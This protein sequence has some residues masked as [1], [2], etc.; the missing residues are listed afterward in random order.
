MFLVLS[1]ALRATSGSEKD[2][3]QA[4]GRVAGHIIIKQWM[5]IDDPG[6]ISKRCDS[7]DSE[8]ASESEHAFLLRIN[9]QAPDVFD[10]S[11]FRKIETPLWVL[12]DRKIPLPKGPPEFRIGEDLPQLKNYARKVKQDSYYISMKI[13]GC[14]RGP[15]G[16]AGVVIEYRYGVVDWERATWESLSED[17]KRTREKP[18][19]RIWLFGGGY[20]VLV[21]REGSDLIVYEGQMVVS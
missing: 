18:R 1:A 2:G 19:F 3:S 13:E 4:V 8:L 9:G 6:T 15:T 10:A 12:A 21:V 17:E 5:E 16:D 20:R 14:A 11:F 7:V